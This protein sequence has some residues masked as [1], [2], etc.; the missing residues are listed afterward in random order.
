MKKEAVKKNLIIYIIIC[1]KDDIL[2]MQKGKKINAGIILAIYICK[3]LYPNNNN[4][5]SNRSHVKT[6]INRRNLQNKSYIQ[7]LQGVILSL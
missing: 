1:F 5:C 7:L 3:F 6:N 4:L 2:T